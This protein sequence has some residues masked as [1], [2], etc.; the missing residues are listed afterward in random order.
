[1]Y[2]TLLA[3]SIPIIAS[4]TVKHHIN[5]EI[6]ADIKTKTTAWVPHEVSTNP[7]ANKSLVELNSYLGTIL[8]GPKGFQIEDEVDVTGI[9]VNYNFND[10]HSSCAHPIRNQQQCGSCWAF[11]S[12]EAFTDR[13]CLAGGPNVVLSPEDLVACDSGNYACNGGYLNEA[14]SFIQNQGLVT[15]TCFPY[16]SGNGS[17]PACPSSC[18]DSE[19]WTQTFKC[20]AGTIVNPTTVS[21]IKAEIYN[22]GP[23]E[24]AFSVYQDFYSYSTG[25]YHHVS[26]DFLGGH[27]IKVLGFG[28]DDASNMDYWLCANSWG[29]SWGMNGFFKIKQGDCGIDQQMYA[30]TPSV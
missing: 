11:G 10:A 2:K 12:S 1:M 20:K 9:P 21:G 19:K 24:G 30:C 27:A 23:V 15:D 16:T 14:W 28:H 5:E 17:V 22:N 6:V 4:A 29:E 3:A 26:G 25:V 18:V 8:T 13:L 7:L